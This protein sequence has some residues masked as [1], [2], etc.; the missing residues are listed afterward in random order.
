MLL[1]QHSWKPLQHHTSERR[2]RSVDLSAKET[3]RNPHAV[4]RHC[5]YLH[6][7]F[8]FDKVLVEL[9]DT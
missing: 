2:I 9:L 1:L 3:M 6:E 8:Y 5:T 7:T 4:L